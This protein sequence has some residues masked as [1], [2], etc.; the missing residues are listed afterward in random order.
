MV[1]EI[2]QKLTITSKTH[3]EPVTLN[4]RKQIQ[5]RITYEGINLAINLGKHKIVEDPYQ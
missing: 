5:E 4:K 2:L 1:G 3:E